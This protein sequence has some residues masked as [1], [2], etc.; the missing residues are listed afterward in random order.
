MVVCGVRFCQH[1]NRRRV[2]PSFGL[3]GFNQRALA[4]IGKLQDFFDFC[5][6]E[7][8]VPKSLHQVPVNGGVKSGQWAE[9][10]QATYVAP[11]GPAG[12]A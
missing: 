2:N 9:Q 8:T 3:N 7:H 6:D 10:N 5:I 11:M 1:G 12:R 4:A